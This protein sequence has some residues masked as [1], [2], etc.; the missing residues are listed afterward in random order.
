[1]ISQTL[2]CFGNHIGITRLFRT[3]FICPFI[4]IF[5]MMTPKFEDVIMT[6]EEVAESFKEIQDSICRG[7]EGADGKASFVEDIWH[8]RVAAEAEA[9]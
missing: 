9:V 3:Q 6:R 5:K 4:P 7:L 1:M 8:H 2:A